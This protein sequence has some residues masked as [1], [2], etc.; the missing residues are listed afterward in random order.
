MYTWYIQLLLAPPFC[1]QWLEEP[2]LIRRWCGDERGWQDA[3][4]P[5]HLRG[6]CYLPTL[7]ETKSSRGEESEVQPGREAEQ[8]GAREVGRADGFTRKNSLSWGLLLSAGMGTVKRSRSSAPLRLSSITEASN[9]P[10]DPRQE[11]SSDHGVLGRSPMSWLCLRSTKQPAGLPI[12]PLI[13]RSSCRHHPP[14]SVFLQMCNEHL[15]P[16]GFRL[17]RETSS[18]FSRVS[19]HRQGGKACNFVCF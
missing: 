5:G 18:L 4:V 3:Q 7:Q 10:A 6:P 15:L 2:G 9:R 8:A 16:S 17:A 1:R 14:C 13:S 12:L 19:Y 11:S